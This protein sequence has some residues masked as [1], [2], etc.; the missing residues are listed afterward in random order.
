MFLCG[1]PSQAYIHQRV[2]VEALNNDSLLH[3]DRSSALELHM[4]D[5]EGVVG[6]RSTENKDLT[7]LKARSVFKGSLAGWLAPLVVKPFEL[8]LKFNKD[9]SLTKK[10]CESLS[11]GSADGI[12]NVLF[13]SKANVDC[14]ELIT[15]YT[16]VVALTK[17]RFYASTGE[18][19]EADIQI[20]DLEYKFVGGDL[21]SDLK[22]R[23][24][25]VNL[26]DAMTHELG[27]FFALEHVPHLNSSMLFTVK[28]S[29]DHLHLDDALG[30]LSLYPPENIADAM[31]SVLGSVRYSDD[32]PVFGSV[33][34]AVNSRTFELQASTLTDTT[35][36]FE[37]CLLEADKDPVVLFSDRFR[38]LNA[39]SLLSS[40]HVGEGIVTKENTNLKG[41]K[42]NPAAKFIDVDAKL[43]FWGGNLELARV[44]IEKGKVKNY[45]NISL[46]NAGSVRLPN[47]LEFLEPE[48]PQL[49][50]WSL[51]NLPRDPLKQ[52]LEPHLFEFF[53]NAQK[54][55]FRTG[56]QAINSRLKISLKLFDSKG[57]PLEDQCVESPYDLEKGQDSWLEC[58]QLVFGEI[59]QLKLSAEVISCTAYMGNTATC[60]DDDH[61]QLTRDQS[62]FLLNIFPSQALGQSSYE[63]DLDKISWATKNFKH[64]H[65]QDMGFVGTQVKTGYSSEEFTKQQFN[66]QVQE[67][68]ACGRLEMAD[69][70][71]AAKYQDKRHYLWLAFVCFLVLFFAIKKIYFAL[72][73]KT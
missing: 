39:I 5:F 62:F 46:E 37:F 60:K 13:S 11:D 71:L 70:A 33:V 31:G 61:D 54:M 25:V 32:K 22:A 26:K 2:Y 67:T 49:F 50:R 27:H 36:A 52:D 15:A 65:C 73:L 51:A 30:A 47:F 40:Y 44:G 34:H 41:E 24:K 1:L 14:T 20:D 55:Q 4:H 7:A 45:V 6:L 29:F 57:Q 53:A 10:A 72:I 63:S 42:L 64:V 56:T 21:G 43:S 12:N 59:Y 68:S 58:D 3:W 38:P 48:V 18:V 8:G 66:E 9:L 17:L 69:K 19:V 16:G 35:G 28:D 23:P